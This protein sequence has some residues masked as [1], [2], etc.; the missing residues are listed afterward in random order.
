MA[1]LTR[2][3]ILRLGALTPLAALFAGLPKGS[4]LQLVAPAE[5]HVVAPITATEIAARHAEAQQ[6]LNAPFER[7]TL[8]V[9]VRRGETIVERWTTSPFAALEVRSERLHGLD[10]GDGHYRLRGFKFSPSFDAN[11]L[12]DFGPRR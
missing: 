3:S 12:A 1:D 9:V 5:A 7:L 8:E 2:R 11:A 4:D 10:V 6:V